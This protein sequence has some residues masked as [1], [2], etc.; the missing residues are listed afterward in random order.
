MLEQS[1]LRAPQAVQLAGALGQATGQRLDLLTPKEIAA[2]FGAEAMLR[3]AKPAL[4]LV[5]DM[6]ENLHGLATALQDDYRIM[7]AA[8][9][10][11]LGVMLRASKSIAE[12]VDE[13]PTVKILALSFLMMIGLLLVAEAFEIHVPKGYVY[14]AMAFSVVVEMLNINARKRRAKPVELHSPY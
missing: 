9:V 12:F 6:P 10:I 3:T 8:N 4:L 13:H 14:F 11:A 7:V 5:D 1:F 2:G